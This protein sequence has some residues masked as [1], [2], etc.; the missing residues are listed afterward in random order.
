MTAKGE[1]ASV[2]KHHTMKVRDKDEDKTSPI[3]ELR[4]NRR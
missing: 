2:S 4:S 1:V 3:P